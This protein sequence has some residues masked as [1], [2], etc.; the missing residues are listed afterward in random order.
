[1]TEADF[2]KI[3]LAFAQ[4]LQRLIEVPNRAKG[5][6]LCV[7]T[8]FQLIENERDGT[9]DIQDLVVTYIPKH[10]RRLRECMVKTRH[11]LADLPSPALF[12]EPFSTDQQRVGR[13]ELIAA[14]MTESGFPALYLDDPIRFGK[15]KFGTTSAYF[16][17][18]GVPELNEQLI[19]CWARR[20]VAP[21]GEIANER[22]VNHELRDNL[23]RAN[24]GM[25]TE[26]LLESV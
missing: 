16:E 11:P 23:A 4:R 14:L 19:A 15:W 9:E 26:D 22:V 20:I 7:D 13:Y 8:V 12:G 18:L 3:Q 25:T 17:F 6:K 1:M 2:N 10:D 24:R 21:F 5:R